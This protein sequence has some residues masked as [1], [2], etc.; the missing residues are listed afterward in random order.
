MIDDQP[1]LDDGLPD[2]GDDPQKDDLPGVPTLANRRKRLAIRSAIEDYDSRRYWER[3]EQHEKK[4]YDPSRIAKNLRA[5]MRSQHLSVRDTIAAISQDGKF[6]PKEYRWLKRVAERGIV[7]TDNRTMTRLGKVADFFGVTVEDLRTF[8]FDRV[9]DY[10]EFGGQAPPG[11]RRYACML[12][13]LVSTEGFEYIEVVLLALH[14]GMENR[15]KRPDEID[16]LT[17]VMSGET[18]GDNKRQQR[19]MRMLSRLLDTGTHEYLKDLIA[20][21]YAV[22]TH[23]WAGIYKE[24]VS[25]TEEYE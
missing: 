15:G 16:R 23:E 20:E 9:V 22:L 13:A 19:C 6:E 8:D 18:P 17:E 5:L 7:Q 1:D 21:L 25:N 24:A 2:L 14:L 10:E 11:F 3:L 12:E 4:Q